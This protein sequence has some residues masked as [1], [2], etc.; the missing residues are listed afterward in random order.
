MNTV[1]MAAADSLSARMAALHL[2][3]AC[4]AQIRNTTTMIFL[5]RDSAR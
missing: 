2:G 5:P 1:M 3:T 4:A